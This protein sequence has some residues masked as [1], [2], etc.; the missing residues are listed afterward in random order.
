M[1]PTTKNVENIK[2]TRRGSVEGKDILVFDNLLPEQEL[3]RVHSGLKRE[4]FGR[5]EWDRKDTEDYKNWVRNMSPQL[6]AEMPAYN[7]ALAMLHHHF[8]AEPYNLHRAYCNVTLYGDMLFTHH[9]CRSDISG[10][11]TAMWF[12]CER[13]DKDWGG[14]TLF[15][16]EAG[17]AEF[18][19]SP[20]AGRLVLFDGRIQHTG[21]APNRI[22]Y[23][24]RFTL[25]FKFYTEAAAMKMKPL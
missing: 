18:V 15:F 17:D 20:A 13:W 8:P 23:E 2:C 14:E 21:R 3:Q 4:G 24:M 9:D 25:V 12:I 1:K 16:N 6:A 7:H 11:Y 10:Y 19:V 5:L 22:C